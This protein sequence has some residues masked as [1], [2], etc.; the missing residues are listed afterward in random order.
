MIELE[1]TKMEA[2]G[3][4]FIIVDD[5]RGSNFSA[6]G[7]ISRLARYLCTRKRSVGSDGLLLIEPSEKADVKMRIFNP[8]GSEVSMCGNGSRAAAYYACHRKIAQGKMTIETR[9]GVLRASVLD[10]AAKI[11]M[12][13]PGAITEK[14]IDLASGKTKLFFVN[15]GVPHAVFM[16]ED[17]DGVDVAG[18]GREVRYH[19]AFSPEGTNADFIQVKNRN[20]IFLRTYERG[21]EE[22]T[23]ACGTGAVAGAIVSSEMGLTCSPVKVKTRGGDALYIYFNKDNRVY[24]DVFL[25]GE[26]RLV[27]EGR[28]VYV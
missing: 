1:F 19:S 24:N 10:D 17:I 18:I 28:V 4:D 26:V 9:A 8:D 6:V 2:A 22:E 14:K 27:Y 5:T 3:N 20:T 23:L 12:T 25:E 21:V 16:A 13:D 11:Q 7:D 15:T